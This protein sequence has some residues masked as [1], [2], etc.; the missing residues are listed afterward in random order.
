MMMMWGFMSSD[1][2]ASRAVEGSLY[3]RTAPTGTS[4]VPGD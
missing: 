4:T 1:V 3:I 2:K